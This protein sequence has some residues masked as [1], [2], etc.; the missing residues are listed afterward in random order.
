MYEKGIL[1]Q[2]DNKLLYKKDALSEGGEEHL[3][4][5]FVWYDVSHLHNFYW[6]AKAFRP[7][8]EW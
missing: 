1:L 2:K 7:N 5:T 8:N 4:K 3:R 6:W